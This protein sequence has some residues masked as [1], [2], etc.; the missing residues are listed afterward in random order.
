MAD[1]S[2]LNWPFFETHHSELVAELTSFCGKQQAAWSSHAKSAE[3]IVLELG[4]A[5]WLEFAVPADFGG[6]TQKLDV[7][8]LSLC[9]QT[10]A[11]HSGLADCMFAM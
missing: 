5:G 1:S 6:R 8:S 4:D 3:Q 9:R 11:Y 10:L 2:F 7:R